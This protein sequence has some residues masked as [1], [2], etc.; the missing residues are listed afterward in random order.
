MHHSPKNFLAISGCFAVFSILI[1]VF[2][3]FIDDVYSYIL[4]SLVMIAISIAEYFE[5][6]TLFRGFAKYSLMMI[7]PSNIFP[8]DDLGIFHMNHAIMYLSM[9]IMGLSIPAIWYRIFSY[10]RVS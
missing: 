10:G 8:L 9:L 7:L 2:S 1:S 4:S 6:L 3:L 5:K